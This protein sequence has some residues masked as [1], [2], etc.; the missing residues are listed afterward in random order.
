MGGEK[1]KVICELKSVSKV[2]LCL[3]VE[4]LAGVAG[5]SALLCTK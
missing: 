1:V 5:A 2:K 3:C 4:M